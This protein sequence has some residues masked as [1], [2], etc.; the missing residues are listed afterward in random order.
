MLYNLNAS[1][2]PFP[3]PRF[4]VA[5]PPLRAIQQHRSKAH[6]LQFW[7]GMLGKCIME[8]LF[9]DL[10]EY[11]SSSSSYTYLKNIQ[12]SVAVEY[13]HAFSYTKA[14]SWWF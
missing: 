8:Y 9:I 10:D 2:L 12:L 11:Q 14:K 13:I 7:R 5:L 6:F 4:P 3:V 1:A